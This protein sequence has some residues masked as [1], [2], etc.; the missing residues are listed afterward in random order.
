MMKFS[1]GKTLAV[2]AVAGGALLASIAPVMAAVSAESPSL[3][4]I[5]VEPDAKIKALGAAIE[6]K[7]TYA[8]P[9]TSLPSTGY[10]YLNVT[11]N[12]FG[13]IASGSASK[14]V[15]CTGGFETT[16]VTVAAQNLAFWPGK[17]FAKADVSAYPHAA[18][19][20]R[21]IKLSY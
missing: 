8:C 19:D 10:V 16:T 7:V 12:V 21:E 6:V 13:R 15:N 20:E 3:A 18:T 4:L 5:R 1:G 17:A 14:T 11:Q 2:A 9:R